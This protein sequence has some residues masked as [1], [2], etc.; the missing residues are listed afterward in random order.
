VEILSPLAGQIKTEANIPAMI[1]FVDKLYG[2]TYDLVN[3][4]QHKMVLF[5]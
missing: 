1:A 5:L 3:K 2:P 4:K